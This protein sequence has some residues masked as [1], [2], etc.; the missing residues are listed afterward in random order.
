MLDAPPYTDRELDPTDTLPPT[1]RSV[2]PGTIVAVP[3]SASEPLPVL[4]SENALPVNGMVIALSPMVATTPLPETETDG[5][6]PATF[7]APNAKR[8]PSPAASKSSPPR[9]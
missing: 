8:A 2:V 3:D 9:V 1:T 7:R 5:Q 6:F 4:T